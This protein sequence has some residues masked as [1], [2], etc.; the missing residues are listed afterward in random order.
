MGP[1][2]FSLCFTLTGI[3]ESNKKKLEPRQKA[4]LFEKTIAMKVG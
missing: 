2:P 1:Y 3:L 4:A